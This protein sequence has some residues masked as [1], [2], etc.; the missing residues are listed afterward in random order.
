[1]ISLHDIHC[2]ALAPGGAGMGILT[3]RRKQ[4]QLLR[5]PI[6]HLFAILCKAGYMKEANKIIQDEV[7]RRGAR[8]GK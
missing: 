7:K 4:E 6:A 8:Q 3:D 5:N 2:G 1:M